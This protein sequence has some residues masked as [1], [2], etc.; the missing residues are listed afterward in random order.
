MSA[1]QKFIL[2]TI[3]IGGL[4][5]AYGFH[6]LWKR[7]IDPRKNGF[8]LLLYFTAHLAS[9]FLLSFLLNFIILRMANFLF[10]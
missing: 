8:S 6:L 9:I 10:R 7:L 1:G 2:F 4:A 3:L 5:A